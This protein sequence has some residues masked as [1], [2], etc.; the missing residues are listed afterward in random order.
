M[1]FAHSFEV[2][3]SDIDVHDH[4]NNVAYL[5]WIQDVAVSHWHSAASAEMLEDYTWFVLRHEIDYKKPAREGE[6]VTAETW[7]GKSTRTRFERFTEIKRGNE[8]LAS[9]KSVWCLLDSKTQKPARIT[10]E[11]RALWK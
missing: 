8:V 4:A 2:R 6:T 5:R 9:A 10:E 7:V 3:K 1:N 11:L